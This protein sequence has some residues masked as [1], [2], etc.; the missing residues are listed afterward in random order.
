LSRPQVHDLI[1]SKLRA[2]PA[3]TAQV[4]T[5][6][7][8]QADERAVIEAGQQRAGFFG[9]PVPVVSMRIGMVTPRALLP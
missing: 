8:A 3:E 4:G 2:R 9:E 7:H 1:M 6:Q 5:E